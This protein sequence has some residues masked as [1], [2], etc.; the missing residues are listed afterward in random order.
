MKRRIL[1]IRNCTE[2]GSAYE[3]DD[4]LAMHALKQLNAAQ[5][6]RSIHNFKSEIA[7]FKAASACEE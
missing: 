4:N 1:S 3:K 2:N 5:H 6:I 7:S